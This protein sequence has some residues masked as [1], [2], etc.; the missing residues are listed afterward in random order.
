[1]YQHKT[2]CRIC[3]SEKLELFLDLG[4][5]PLANSFLKNKQQFAMEKFYPLIAY[6]CHNCNLAQLLDVVDK[7]EMFSDYIY[8]TSGMP[9]I[10]SHFRGYA[11]DI[12]ARFL[13]PGDFVMEIASNDGILLKFFQDAGYKVLGI[14]PAA[15]VVKVAENLG[16]TTIVDFFNA[17]L[18]EKIS[19]E[20]GKPKVIMANNV[21]AHID[22]H[23]DLAE[24]LNK[25]LAK[26]GV[27]VLEAPYLTDMFDNLTYDTIYHEHL[28]FLAVRPLQNLFS[29]YGLEIFDVQ[30]HPVQGNSIRAFVGHAGQHPVSKKVNE[31][32]EDEL[33]RGFN[34]PA[35]YFDLAARVRKQRGKLI[36]MLKELKSQG[37]KI[38]AYGAPAK[39]N[40][41]LNYCQIGTDILDYA[42]EDLP[43]KKNLFT[44]GMHIPTVDAAYAHS[45]EPDYYL[46][47][48]WN[49]EKPIL[50]KEQAYLKKG[51][52]F[53]V[54][55]E[56]VRIV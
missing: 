47:L 52:K 11:E 46:M 7:E 19:S 18:A 32:T 4:L 16:V 42:L 25:L 1:M 22:D 38:A 20:Q 44:P 40:T 13:Q 10:S 51:G 27:F 24:G 35:T 39:G 41:L 17:K 34:K 48:A 14:D 30:V 3:K 53:I 8:F 36:T 29:Q 21:V 49:Y 56:G 23:H 55:V 43:A 50:E 31:L 45:H 37:K 5:Q 28:S 12:M 26:D 6:F 9:K 15:N 33:A 54:P 2:Q